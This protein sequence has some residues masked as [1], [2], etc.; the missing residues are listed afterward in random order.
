MRMDNVELYEGFPSIFFAR[1][2]AFINISF[3]ELTSEQI[4]YEEETYDEKKEGKFCCVFLSSLCDGKSES[5]EKTFDE[6][7]H[8]NRSNRA[9]SKLLSHHTVKAKVNI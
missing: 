5:I 3:V 6:D 1:S 9:R 8:G 2:L 7:F 4:D